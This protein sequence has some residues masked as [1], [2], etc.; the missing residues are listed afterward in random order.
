MK[1]LRSPRGIIAL[2]LL[3]VIAAGLSLTITEIPFGS[4]DTKVGSYYVENGR[5]ETGAANIV[6]SVVTGYRALDTLGEV[7]VL[8]IAAM[9]LSAVLAIEKKKRKREVE[10]SSLVLSTGCRALFPFILLLGAY[11][12]IHGHL[13]P[14]GGFQGGAV[15]GSAF[16]LVY[17]GYPERRISTTGTDV[18]ESLGGLAFVILGLIGF[19]VG[20][21]YFL[22]NFLPKGELYSLFS[23]GILPLIY[24]A[25]GLKVGAE[26]G[27]IIDR[28]ME[29]TR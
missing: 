25:I 21:S 15:I 14:G 17:L 23:A 6:T 22:S 12:F 28:M 7:T 10:E 16:L 24:I 26:F 19:A 1:D 5:E 2:V 3:A 13:T 11:L 29:E 8:F 9:G 27:G 18:T 20:S 4:P